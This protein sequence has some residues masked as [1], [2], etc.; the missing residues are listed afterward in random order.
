[1][2]FVILGLLVVLLIGFIFT[3]YKAAS[4][5]RWYQITA[6]SLTLLLSIA[7]LFPAAGVLASRSAWHKVKEDLERRV[8]EVKAEHR[9]IKYGDP[10]NPE[11]GVGVAE[12]NHELEQISTEAGRRWRNLQLQ[13]VA[14]NNILLVNPDP[15]AADPAGLPPD[16]A[17]PAAAA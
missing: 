8:A 16:P 5:W 1:M 10:T 7:F 13:N 11:L 12:L 2:N 9:V 17:A 14:N 15:A 4:S 6:A 3:V